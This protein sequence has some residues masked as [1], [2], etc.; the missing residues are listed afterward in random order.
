MNHIREGNHGFFG[1]TNP[2][3]FG[4][5]DVS[6]AHFDMDVS[7]DVT[8]RTAGG[9]TPIPL[10]SRFLAGIKKDFDNVDKFI[11]KINSFGRIARQKV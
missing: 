10:N 3:P 7:V 8:F 11:K 1:T 5:H 4:V 6:N 2:H 9:A